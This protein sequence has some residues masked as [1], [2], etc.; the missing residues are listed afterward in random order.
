MLEGG[1]SNSLLL[2]SKTVINRCGILPPQ[3]CCFSDVF[4]L[5]KKSH[6]F[7]FYFQIP[8]FRLISIFKYHFVD[9]FLYFQIPFFKKMDA[10]SRIN[11]KFSD[12]MRQYVF[13]SKRLLHP[14]NSP[15]IF[16]PITKRKLTL[17]RKHQ[18]FN[19]WRKLSHC[20]WFSIRIKIVC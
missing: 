5:G 7:D 15:I 20:S 9:W 6:S 17:V 4:I 18:L 10:I 2:T 14:G 13:I 1:I 12:N 11:F 3:K 16:Y 8:F 19:L